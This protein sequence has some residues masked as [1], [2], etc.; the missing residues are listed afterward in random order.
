MKLEF[1]I[2]SDWTLAARGCAYMKLHSVK[3]RT[4]EPQH[5]ECRRVVSL[6]SVAFKID[7]IHSFDIRHSLF[8]ILF[9]IPIWNHGCNTRPKFLSRL[10][11]PFFCSPAGLTPETQFSKKKRCKFPS[12]HHRRF[13]NRILVSRNQHPG[14]RHQET[15]F[16][17]PVTSDQQ[18]VTVLES[19]TL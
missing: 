6:R 9:F 18:P 7:R 14:T 19:L 13:S 5:I 11:R 1:L 16:Q 12:P 15:S 8:D 17:V 10:S 3:K 4:A 2:Q